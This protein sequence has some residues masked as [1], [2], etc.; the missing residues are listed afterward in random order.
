MPK[1]TP[2]LW[3][4]HEAEEAANFYVT[5]FP[6]SKIVTTSRYGEAGPGKAGS[7]MVVSFELDGQ[8]FSA[9]NGG[10]HMQINGAVSFVIDCADQAEVDWYW[11]KLADGG[12]TSQC[13]WLTDRFGVTWQVVPE[14]LLR[15]LGDADRQKA[16]R[17]MQAMLK[18]TRIEI[19]KL[20]AAY[21]G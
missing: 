21:A 20:E 13:G 4:D 19:D 14:A 9:L 2:F 15:L 12:Q 6:N 5:V 10:P 17:V 8:V 3:F 11:D 1:I 18:M 7:V 16:N